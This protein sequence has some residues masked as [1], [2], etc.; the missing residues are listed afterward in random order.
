[1]GV[2]RTAEEPGGGLG[3]IEE[4]EEDDDLSVD[5]YFHH[6]PHLPHSG[7]SSTNSD[8]LNNNQVDEDKG[9][10]TSDC[11]VCRLSLFL[12]LLSVLLVVVVVARV[13]RSL[14]K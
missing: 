8:V 7:A 5:S 2:H 3:M 9:K 11:L 1:M 4:E 6:Y 12:S 14:Y 10:Y 13:K